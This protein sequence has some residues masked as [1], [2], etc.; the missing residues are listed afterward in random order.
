MEI[1]HR[2]FSTGVRTWQDLLASEQE[3]DWDK[4]AVAALAGLRRP[5]PSVLIC[6]PHPPLVQLI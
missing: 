5:G 4:V 2:L 3:S 6:A 1:P